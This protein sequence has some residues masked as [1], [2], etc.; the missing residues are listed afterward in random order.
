MAV[1]FI[2]VRWV[3]S[4]AQGESSGS[5]GFVRFIIASSRSAL[6][7]LGSSD[8]LGR[9]IGARLVHSGATSKSLDTFEPALGVVEFIP[10][11]WVHSG[12]P[13]ACTG[14]FGFV[15]FIRPW[16][17]S[18]PSGS[19]GPFWRVTSVVVFI[20]VNFGAFIGSSRSFVVRPW[21]RRV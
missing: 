21:C 8:S 10:L 18:C 9:A 6:V 17:S 2:L 15:G 13:S 12:A 4:G 7:H 20:R 3:H 5:F 11:H 19:L 14:S 1:G 16:W